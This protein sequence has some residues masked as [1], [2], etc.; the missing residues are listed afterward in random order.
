MTLRPRWALLV[1]AAVLGAGIAAPGPGAARRGAAADDRRTLL[2][3]I[4]PSQQTHVAFGERSHWLQPWRAYLTTVPARKLANALGIVFNP[5]SQVAVKVSRQAAAA[6]IHRARLEISWCRVSYAEPER[7]TGMDR[8]ETLLRAVKAAG[9]RPLIL[10]NANHGCPGPVRNLPIDVV[11]PA[12]A[13]DTQLVLDEQSARAVVPGH[14]GLDSGTP[15]KAAAYLFTKVTGTTVTLSRPLA[16]ALDAG[17]HSASTLKYEPFTRPGDDAFAE[18]IG[19][20]VRYVALVTDEVRQILGSDRFDVEVWNELSFGSDFLDASTYYDPP[21]VT[22]DPRGTERAILERTIAYIRDPSHRLRG[23]GI[24]DGFAN[25]RPWEAGSNVPPG[26]TAIDKHPYP[27]RREFPRQAVFSR[28]RPVDA[29]GRPDGVRDAAGRWRDSFVPGYTAFLP[30]YFLTAIQTETVIRDL[31]PVT[32]DVYGAPHGRATRPA[33]SPPPVLWV[34]EAGMDPSSV[35]APVL[36]SFHAKGAL[37]WA[38]SWVNKGAAAIFF[39]AASSPGWGIVSPAE[40]GGGKT[41]QALGRLTSTL[42]RDA[43][44]ITRPRS[45]RLHAI[46]DSSDRAQFAGDGTTMHPALS[47]RDVV[48]FFPF[49]SSNGR[50]VV[51]VY[52][53]TRDLLHP[54]RPA[55]PASDPRRFDMP[56]QRFRLTLGGVAGLTGS[57]TLAD[58]LTGGEAPVSVVSR[59]GG[60]VVV[61]V[62]LTDSPRLLVLSAARAR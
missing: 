58:P 53:M 1:A 48:A 19:G 6:G 39:Y 44:P 4:Q 51:A 14:T 24:G 7:L 25:E 23:V 35:P 56:P 22:S 17:S 61:D 26:T 8:I 55:L 46:A 62:A 54:Y 31:S 33:G 34:T 18:T 37:R 40:P 28:V 9:L 32:T 16:Q 45:L 10:L 52:V 60:R 57:V 20:W 15:S 5:P 12:R 41:L 21:V 2:E 59:R 42:A 38:T 47:N 50:V 11:A 36:P 13:G 49:Q 30:E 27:P 43:R 29:R 3:P